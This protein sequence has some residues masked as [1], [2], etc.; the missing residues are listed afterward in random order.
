MTPPNFN[1]D[2]P[3]FS[4]ICL[5]LAAVSALALSGNLLYLFGI[6]YATPYGSPL[7]KIHPASYW[8]SLALFGVVL[9]AQWRSRLLGDRQLIAP[10]LFLGATILVLLYTALILGL[11]LANIVV[12][13]ITPAIFLLLLPLLSLPRLRQ[14]GWVLHALLLLNSLIGLYEF[15]SG[16]AII[17][18]VLID[19]FG[20]GEAYDMSEWGEWRARGLT[21]HPLSGT[22][23]N[24][25]VIVHC[26]A[27]LFF[28]HANRWHVFALLHCLVSLPAFG[29]RTS[30][31]VTLVFIVLMLGARLMQAILGKKDISIKSLAWA[32]FSL[33]FAVIGFYVAY[34]LGFFDQLIARLADDNGS[35]ATRLTALEIL[36]NTPWSE[37]LFGNFDQKLGQRMLVY[38]TQ[39]GIEISWVGMILNYGLILSLMLL[40]SLFSALGSVVRYLSLP[41]AWWAISA[42]FVAISSGTG[43]ASKEL[44]LIL[45]LLIVVFLNNEHEKVLLHPSGVVCA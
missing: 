11:P 6:D 31:T 17:P 19:Y 30:I 1:L 38:G 34:L 24:A 25:V 3:R 18:P 9:H 23:L 32:Y 20:T 27:T 37:I 13:W 14:V 43:L 10:W 12:T 28:A 15:A 7:G 41:H 33:L 29:G 8:A 36:G 26:A 44:S 5:F 22:L 35:A 4:Y 42:Y 21:G 2:M 45:M 16:N 40:I 39:Y